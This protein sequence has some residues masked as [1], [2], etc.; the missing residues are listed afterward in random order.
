[1]K[2]ACVLMTLMAL[3][4]S[5]AAAEDPA[6][7]AAVRERLGARRTAIEAAH[8]AAERECAQRFFVTDCLEAARTRRREAL[9]EIDL[10]EATLD[11]AER[12]RRAGA[13]QQRIDAK[14]ARQEADQRDRATVPLLPPEAA[15]AAVRPGLRL[16]PLPAPAAGKPQAAAGTG[17]GTEES[18]AEAA[19]RRRDEQRAKAAYEARQ[20]EALE[21]R[22]AL[23]R[24]QQGKPKAAPLPPVA[25]ASEAR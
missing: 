4:S 12:S 22:Q 1:M 16:A 23:Q 13:R 18:S 21:R 9:I 17:T 7:D 15:S 20:Q 3:V 8:V 2:Q 5:V 11:D 24:R 19:Q 6:S 10:S 25:P 14:R